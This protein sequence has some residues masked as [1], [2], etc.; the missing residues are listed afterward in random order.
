V[1]GEAA[2]GHF[3]YGW[4]LLEFVQRDFCVSLGERRIQDLKDLYVKR[5]RNG[6]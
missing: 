5:M 3:Y 2:V 4:Q 6:T 1:Q